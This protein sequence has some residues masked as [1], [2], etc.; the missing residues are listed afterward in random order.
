MNDSVKTKQTILPRKGVRASNTVTSKAEKVILSHKEKSAGEENNSDSITKEVE[1]SID[2]K[3]KADFSRLA[4]E[5]DKVFNGDNFRG[6][7][8]APADIMLAASGRKIWDIPDKEVQSAADLA[9]LSAKGFVKT[10][11]KWIAVI[12]LSFS[13]LTMYGGRAGLHIKEVREEK[14]RLPKKPAEIVNP[15]RDNG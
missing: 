4:K 8:R 9:S 12:L 13:L 5:L 2:K 1:P 6:V 3:A 11:P 14:K 15:G 10:D 7:V